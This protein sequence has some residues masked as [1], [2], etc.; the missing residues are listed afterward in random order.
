V[1]HGDGLGSR[2]FTVANTG[3]GNSPAVDEP[4]D[5]A[6]NSTVMLQRDFDH[7]SEPAQL[8][9]DETGVYSAY[10][11][12]LDRIEMEVG[13]TNGYLLMKDERRPLPVGSTLKSGRFYWHAGPGFLGEY[14]LL[15]ERA[16]ATL[17]L[18]RVKI[19][20]KVYA[21]RESR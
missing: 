21:G 2:Y 16:D 13:A 5:S 8:A 7:N 6:T 3:G 14:D 19:R 10:M 18:V 12:E 9:P 17:V 11:E 1:G 15:F 20:P 4:V